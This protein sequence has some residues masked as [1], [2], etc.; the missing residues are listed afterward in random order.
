[1]F[2]LFNFSPE[3]VVWD[4]VNNNSCTGITTFAMETPHNCITLPNGHY[5][6][7]GS[8]AASCQ[9]L[10]SPYMVRD[11][12]LDHSTVTVNEE[13][14]THIQQYVNLFFLMLISS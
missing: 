5:V 2:T 4:R 3:E 12:Q 1:M 7:R 8:H 14:T 9:H 6:G 11:L 13:L 10:T